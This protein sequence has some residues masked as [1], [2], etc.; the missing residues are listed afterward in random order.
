MSSPRTARTVARS[1]LGLSACVAALGLSACVAA[2]ALMG[3]DPGDLGSV[4]LDGLKP[5]QDTIDKIPLNPVGGKLAGK[6]FAVKDARMH[7]DR[8]VGYERVDVLLRGDKA[9][10]PCGK[11]ADEKAAGIWLRFAGT[12]TVKAKEYQVSP[13]KPAPVSLHM[14]VSRD[15][16]WYGNGD[17]AALL[18]IERFDEQ[19]HLWGLVGLFRR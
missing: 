11:L 1:V 6:P 12:T 16:K 15:D 14:E 8:R 4:P 19:W 7:I 5:E 9:V 10:T 18:L 13:Q 3:C 2:I 17:A